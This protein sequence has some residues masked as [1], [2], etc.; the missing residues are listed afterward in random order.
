LCELTA[1]KKKKQAMMDR[2][3]AV[4]QRRLEELKERGREQ[5][6][7]FAQEEQ[8]MNDSLHRAKEDLHRNMKEMLEKA[9]LASYVQAM[10][11]TGNSNGGASVPKV[12]LAYQAKL[13][14]YMHLYCAAELNRRHLKSERWC[15][16]EWLEEVSKLCSDRRA[17][18]ES[19]LRLEI[20]DRLEQFESQE[21]ERSRKEE[22]LLDESDHW[23]VRKSRRRELSNLSIDSDIS[24]VDAALTGLI[25]YGNG[26]S[27][28]GKESIQFRTNELDG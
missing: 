20:S 28:L 21:L 26:K 10:K 2:K 9:N 18:I 1:S 7:K 4:A 14:F 11:K 12:V 27:L 13:C 22:C 25:Y 8:A 5:R 23:N 6:R 17:S 15:E 19:R 24:L 3:I 16:I